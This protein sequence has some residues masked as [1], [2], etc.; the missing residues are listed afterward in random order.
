MREENI[1]ILV[2]KNSGGE[3]T[4]AKLIAARE[5]GIPVL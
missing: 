4:A 5:L 3:A 2:T 1:D